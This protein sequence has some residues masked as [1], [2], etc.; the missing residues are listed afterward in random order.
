MSSVLVLLRSPTSFGVEPST[1][2]ERTDADG[3]HVGAMSYRAHWQL[4]LKALEEL[5]RVVDELRDKW[6]VRVLKDKRAQEHQG[7]AVVG[8]QPVQV[9]LRELRIEKSNGGGTNVHKVRVTSTDED[10]VL[11]TRQPD[12]RLCRIVRRE[13]PVDEHD[14]RIKA[15]PVPMGGFERDYA[16]RLIQRRIAV[17]RRMNNFMFKII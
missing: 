6:E 13:E 16:P 7:V 5:H 17:I 3:V 10:R 14:R 9:K 4:K 12:R 8:W 1:K 15:A 11:A 2:A